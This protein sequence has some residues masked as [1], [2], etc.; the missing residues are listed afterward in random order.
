M[1]DSPMLELSL[2]STGNVFFEGEDDDDDE[3]AHSKSFASA[4]GSGVGA[5]VGQ[6][7]F[8]NNSRGVGYASSVAS[9]RY[10]AAPPFASPSAA[11]PNVTAHVVRKYIS[12]AAPLFWLGMV[13]LMGIGGR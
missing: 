6:R 8:N 5:G 9:S 1:V 3:N 7:S 13:L 12:A 10:T 2:A 11:V 4:A